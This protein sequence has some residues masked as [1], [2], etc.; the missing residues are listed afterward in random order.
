ME[1]NPH[2]APMPADTPSA[3][4][5]A[6]AGLLDRE[7][8]TAFYTGSL[9]LLLRTVLLQPMDGTRRLFTGQGEGG[10]ANAM[11]L[12][13]STALLYMIVPWM[14]AGAAARQFLGFSAVIKLGLAMLCCMLLVSCVS[15]VLKCVGGR[16][17][18]RQEL[19]TG[20]LCGIPLTGLLLVLVLFRMVWGDP[21][22]L[23]M[24]ASGLS[25]I[26]QKAGLLLLLVFYLLLMMINIL[27]QSLRA[28]GT[29]EMAAW[30]LSPLG[31]FLS[32][33]L[34]VKIT[35]ALF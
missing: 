35:A 26:M 9:P 12:M 7:R 2:P 22:G 30:Y 32:L 1:N 24:L 20:A 8:L 33:Y 5:A 29:K 14:L 18:F 4:A 11:L 3:A 16:P 15:F 13:A 6:P 17:V 31:I 21:S 27:Q 34:T 25:A 10:P 19:L 28:G 23:M